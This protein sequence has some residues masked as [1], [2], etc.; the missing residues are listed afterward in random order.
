M[1]GDID[2]DRC[3]ECATLPATFICGRCYIAGDKPQRSDA[4]NGDGQ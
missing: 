4:G 2:A 1:T 3:P